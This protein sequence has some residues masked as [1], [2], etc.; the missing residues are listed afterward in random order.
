MDG[1][2]GGAVGGG[3]DGAAVVGGAVVVI[4][5]K[6]FMT[7]VSALPFQRNAHPFQRAVHLS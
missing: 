6:A 5:D 7:S 2:A 1:R 3:A 4:R